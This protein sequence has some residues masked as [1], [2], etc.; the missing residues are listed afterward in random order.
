MELILAGNGRPGGGSPLTPIS[1]G[2]LGHGACS[3]ASESR[4]LLRSFGRCH[5][6]CPD[7]VESPPPKRSRLGRVSPPPRVAS[8]FGTVW[9]A[10]P[11]DVLSTLLKVDARF[12]LDHSV[13]SS[14]SR[15]FPPS[16]RKPSMRT[17]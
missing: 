4:R 12:A 9:G 5:R 7:R 1:L 3:E 10:Y 13:P 11:P 16:A 8:S 2:G 15:T 17:D 6:P 14:E